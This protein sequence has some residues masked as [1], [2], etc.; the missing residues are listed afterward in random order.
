MDVLN[1]TYLVYQYATCNT[2]NKAQR[3]GKSEVKLPSA[4]LMLSINMYPVKQNRTLGSHVLPCPPSF[5]GDN[6]GPSVKNISP[7]H[8]NCIFLRT[9]FLTLPKHGAPVKFCKSLHLF[10]KVKL[11]GVRKSVLYQKIW[12][13]AQELQRNENYQCAG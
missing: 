2:K 7:N 6:S 8:S 5:P 11:T 13:N 3:F 12:E 10:H 1:P 4:I 9:S